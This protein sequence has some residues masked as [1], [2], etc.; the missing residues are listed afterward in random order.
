MYRAGKNS[1]ASNCRARQEWQ[2][3]Q[4]PAT[5]RLASC[6]VR[7]ELGLELGNFWDSGP[8]LMLVGSRNPRASE[9]PNQGPRGSPRN[10]ACELGLSRSGFGGP[11]P[12]RAPLPFPL[13]P[14]SIRLDLDGKSNGWKLGQAVGGVDQALAG[15]LLAL[16]PWIQ[17]VGAAGG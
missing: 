16:V 9:D 11:Q 15:S 10:W 13:S 1:I 4:Q 17:E 12:A 3:D 7:A 14:A 6:Y 8:R 5:P 2:P